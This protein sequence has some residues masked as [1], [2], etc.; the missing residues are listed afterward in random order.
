MNHRSFLL[1]TATTVAATAALAQQ[2]LIF[3]LGA[4]DRNPGSCD[5]ADASM[6]RLQSVT[7]AGDAAQIKSNGGIN[8]VAKMVSPGVY[9]TK[10]RLGGITYDIEV[11]TTTSPATLSVAE[12]KLGCRWSGSAS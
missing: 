2:P 4:S 8:D 6:S 10:W 9:R 7:I 5:A 11:D 12:P 3:R 1:A